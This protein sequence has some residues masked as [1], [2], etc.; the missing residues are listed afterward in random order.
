MTVALLRR[1]L[2]VLGSAMSILTIA[3]CGGGG[4]ATRWFDRTFTYTTGDRS[5]QV[6]VDQTGRYTVV[7]YHSGSLPNGAG[8]R[9]ALDSAGAFSAQSSDGTVGFQGSI[10]SNGTSFT[11]VVRYAGAD[12]FTGTGA[13]L[14]PGNPTPAALTG[15]YTST[16]P[17]TEVSLSVDGIGH[18][19]LWLSGNTERGWGVLDVASDGSMTSTDGRNVASLTLTGGNPTLTVSRLN[20]VPVSLT[21]PMTRQGRAKWTVMVF[22]NAANDLQQ[23]GPPNVNQMETIGSSPDVNIVV[24][25]KQANCA[26]C[27]SPE[28]ASTRRYL[29]TKD[30]APYTVNSRL[31][32][33]LGPNV[34]MGDWRQ[35][36]AF[37]RW[38]QQRYPA[39]RYAL[40]IWNHG[41]GW[42][43]TRSATIPALRSVSIDDATNNEIQ[44][45]QLPQALNVSPKLDLLIFDASLMQMTEVAYEVRNSAD[46]MVGS[47][48]SP[49]GEGYVYN[50][51]L[52]DLVQDPSM[53]PARF[54]E[55]IVTR[56]LES[57]G[58]NSNSTQSAVDLS[59]LPQVATALDGFAQS[60]MFHATTDGAA[61]RDARRRAENYA[62]VDNKDLWHFAELLRTTATSSGLRTA[63]SAVQTALSSAI[64]ANAHGSRH[65][66]SHGLAIY[67]PEPASYLMNYTN[68]ALARVTRWDE[69]LQFQTPQ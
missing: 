45:W 27:G 6:S 63:A 1:C 36:Y 24:Q 68:L 38:S 54:A 14:A 43:S 49:P 60:L 52:G 51:F 12:L 33:D 20:G 65:P 57:Y 55:S 19:T 42:R 62:Y 41:A 58:S 44:T 15:S 32:E 61:I 67:L 29:I 46:I 2:A 22:L 56:T 69:W 23:F 28:W 16:D 48:E 30:S 13:A 39:D 11:C 47:E 53:T 25:W 4:H 64:I 3:G 8:A 26:R 5:C 31:V 10:S 34:D 35:L 59:R 18:A 40:V 21:V 17:D 7:A 37:I 9:G 66:N 50:T